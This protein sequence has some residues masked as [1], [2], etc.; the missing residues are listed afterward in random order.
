MKVRYIHDNTI[1]T[2]EGSHT[3]FSRF[4]VAASM[5]HQTFSGFQCFKIINVIRYI[6]YLLSYQANKKIGKYIYILK[7]GTENVQAWLGA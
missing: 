2:G 5:L 6:L 4:T 3:Y 1:M 7:F